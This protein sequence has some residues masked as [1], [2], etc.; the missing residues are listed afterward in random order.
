MWNVQLKAEFVLCNAELKLFVRVQRK[1]RIFYPGEKAPNDKALNRW[2][3]RIQ[4]KGMC[5]ETEILRSTRNIG[6]ECGA[7]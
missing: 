2:F 1:W 7:H 6:R 5:C 4:R 3:E